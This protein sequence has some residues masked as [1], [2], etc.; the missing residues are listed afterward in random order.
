MIYEDEY[1]Y[2][3]KKYFEEISKDKSDDYSD[4]IL[5][6][7]YEFNFGDAGKQFKLIDNDNLHIIPVFIEKD[8]AA[9]EMWEKYESLYSIK[10]RFERRNRFLEIK[11]EF[12]SYVINVNIKNYPFEREKFYGRIPIENLEDYYSEEYGFNADDDKV[13]FF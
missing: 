2:F 1:Y 3:S 9:V 5:E 6:N 12:L 11:D 10:D 4:E 13:M 7:I 8:K